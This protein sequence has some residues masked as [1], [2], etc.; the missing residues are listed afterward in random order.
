MLDYKIPSGKHRINYQKWVEMLDNLVIRDRCTQLTHSCQETTWSVTALIQVVSFLL[1]HG[2][3]FS[4]FHNFEKF[5][6]W[7]LFIYYT[8][9]LNRSSQASKPKK[10]VR[11]TPIP[12][13]FSNI[14]GFKLSLNNLRID[15]IER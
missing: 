8:S 3:G 5:A 2:A 11:D 15:F 13:C 1:K 4:R 14:H 10:R 9:E 7:E 6:I 12:I